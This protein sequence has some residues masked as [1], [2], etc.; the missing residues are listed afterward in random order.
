MSNSKIITISLFCLV[1][2]T[3]VGTAYVVAADCGIYLLGSRVLSGAFVGINLFSVTLGIINI[4]Q[5][6]ARWER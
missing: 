5:M 6:V 1:A 2:A 4:R 3:A